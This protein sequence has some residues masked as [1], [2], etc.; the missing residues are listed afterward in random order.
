MR[1]S[2]VHDRNCAELERLILS[3]PGYKV[4]W[5]ARN[6]SEALRCCAFER[7]DLLLIDLGAPEVDSMETTRYI[8]SHYPCPILLMA[9][10]LE[11]DAAR[12]FEAMGQGAKDVINLPLSGEGFQA[13]QSREA[14]L[15]KIRTLAT[16]HGPTLRPLQ[17]R[18]PKPDTPRV[19]REPRPEHLGSGLRLAP[20]LLA[21]GSSTGGPGALA[22]VLA[23]LPATLETTVIIVQ[24]VD[25]EFSFDLAAWLNSQ[26]HFHVQLARKGE[27]PRKGHV[28]VA[29]SN[30]H[31]ILTSRLEF[32]YT[33]EPR[34]TH[35][36]P[37]VDVFFNSAAQHWPRPEIAVLLTGM[38]R[39]GASGLANLK[40]KG[41]YTIAQDE[42]TSVVYGMPKAAKELG[43]AVDIL[44]LEQIGMAVAK[45]HRLGKI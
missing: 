23:N 41:W 34:S 27:T 35:Y 26:T 30:D 22:K 11:T 43:A 10:S 36:R 4:A 25:E 20:R 29:S 21:L 39:D 24:H 12:I 8:M 40:E 32:D 1:I 28:Y 13:Q 14:F 19:L 37:S 7:P 31:L 16:L 15:K 38:G 2:I 17:A 33:P 42:A 9:N 3:V 44:P 5:T 18:L 6:G 45:R